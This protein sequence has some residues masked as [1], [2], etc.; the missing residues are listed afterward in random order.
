MRK[1]VPKGLKNSS[2]QKLHNYLA[3]PTEV[4]KNYFLVNSDFVLKIQ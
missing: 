3:D 4:K 1:Q 2:L